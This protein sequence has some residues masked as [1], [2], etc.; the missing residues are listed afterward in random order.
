MIQL[1]A[2]CVFLVCIARLWWLQVA[3]HEIYAAQ[4]EQNRVRVLPIQAPRGRIYDRNGRLLVTNHSVW[5]IVIGYQDLGIVRQESEFLAGHLALDPQWLERRLEEAV[6]EPKYGTIVIKE[7]A[8]SEDVA[9]VMAHQYERPYLRIE[10]A[11][12]RQYLYGQFAAHVLGYVGEVSRRELESGPFSRE[13]GYKLGDLIGKS[14][15]ERTYNDILTG[16]NGQ[17]VVVVDSRGQLQFELNRVEPIPGRDLYTTLDY[18]LQV[19]AE[20]QADLMARGRGVIAAMDPNNGGILAL[21]SRPAFDPNLF[22]QRSQT[23]A[24]KAEINDLYRQEDHPLFNR[25]IQGTYPT[26]STWKI[27]MAVAALNSGVIAVD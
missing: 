9:W 4:A 25:V 3:N 20:L 2:V 24:I 7:S 13:Q 21:V 16:R 23:S 11:P 17:R 1:L 14:G 15:I 5:N 27:F 18:D 10:S 8:N 19:A 26:G 22:A 6:Y 12:Q